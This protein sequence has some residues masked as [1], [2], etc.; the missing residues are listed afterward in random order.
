MFGVA[1]C[2]FPVGLGP[3]TIFTEEIITDAL[4]KFP[5]DDGATEST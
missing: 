3:R 2:V 4:L 5:E 1:H